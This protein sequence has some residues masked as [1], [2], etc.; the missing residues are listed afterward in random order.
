MLFGLALSPKLFVL[1]EVKV[2]H[3][4]RDLGKKVIHLLF[5]DD[6]K[7]YGQNKKGIEKLVN[8]VRIFRKDIRMGFSINKC[9]TRG[10]I[11]RSEGVQLPN[12]EVKKNNEDRGGYKYWVYWKLID[13]GA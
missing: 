8:L 1:R 13:L 11:S 12:D 4:F 2:G 9:V 5:M 7:L 10:T 3:Q 6:L